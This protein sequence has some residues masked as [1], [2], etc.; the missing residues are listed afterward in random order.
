VTLAILFV[1]TTAAAP[2]PAKLI[3]YWQLDEDPSVTTT[4]VDSV[5]GLKGTIEGATSAAGK[6][7]KALSFDGTNDRVQV[8]GF[9]V[10]LQGTIVLWINPSLAKG[11]ERFL[12]TGGD[13]E[14][15]LRSNGELKNELFDNG[16][17][18]LGTG[19]GVIKANQ[20]QHV[21]LTYDGV[22]KTV[23]I[24]VNGA[25]KAAG[26][27][28]VPAVPQGQILQFGSRPDAATTEYYQGLL[29]DVQMYDEVLAAEETKRLY[30]NPGM[31]FIK[32]TTKASNPSP[33]D[34]AQ[35]VPSDTFLTWTAGLY[36]A[37]LSP[38][39]RVFFS[40]DF[41]DVNDRKTPVTQ[42]VE[43][44]P[45]EGTL[46]LDLGKTYYWRVDEA[47]SVAG[48][49]GG[50]LWRFTVADFFV[51]DDFEDYND[52]EPHCIFNTWIDGW[53]V[54][55][56]GSVVGYSQSPF[57]EQKIVHGG[58]QSMPLLYDNTGAAKYSEAVADLDDLGCSRDWTAGGVT[59]LSLWLRGRLPDN[60][61]TGNQSERMYV[62]I[63]NP[64][65]RTGTVYNP[66]AGAILLDTWTQWKI[67]L[68]EFSGQ[69]VNL[70]N[71]AR[72]IIGLGDKANPKTGGAGMVYIDDIR[73]SRPT[74]P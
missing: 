28:N 12:G 4:L 11:K 2:V 46:D 63:A 36:A 66:D 47:N 32:V 56:N 64:N 55:A 74:Q 51:V 10:P 69:G 49:D 58:R 23:G 22:A 43:R 9:A 54:A 1:L 44:Y 16:S 7:G 6:V 65:G 70:A 30:E 26:A 35:D 42:D 59:V 25:P 39:N 17:T 3:H 57:A 67:D 24:Y 68:K 48:W 61:V 5:G 21:A 31:T 13:F 37:G 14:V 53:D 15:W 34:G 33:A 27:A 40:A 72:L 60:S 38:R 8:P 62:A 45:A 50:D 52:V 18:T 20:W 73:L 29:D 41:N 71:V 19:A